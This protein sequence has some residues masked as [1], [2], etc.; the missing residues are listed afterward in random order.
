MK[1]R[2]KPQDTTGKASPKAQSTRFRK[3]AREAGVDPDADIDEVMRRLAGQPKA[4][5]KHKEPS[6]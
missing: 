1:P 6:R 3:A 4:S 2:S 5:T